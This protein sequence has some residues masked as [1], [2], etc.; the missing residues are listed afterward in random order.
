MAPILLLKVGG[1]DAPIINVIGDYE[2]WFQ[3]VIPNE[4][5]GVVDLRDE[6]P[7]WPKDFAAVIIMGSPH[8]VYA[9]LPWLPS[10]LD[11]VSDLLKKDIPVLGVCFGHQMICSV[12]GGQV[13]KSDKGYEVGTV[14]LRATPEGLADPLF[15]PLF[16]NEEMLVNE[17]H[18]DS[19]AVLPEETII[20]AENDHDSF[21]A[22]R[23]SEKVWSVQFHPEIGLT[24]AKAVMEDYRPSLEAKGLKV[25]RLIETA[26]E[27]PEA[28]SL[29][30][31]FVAYVRGNRHG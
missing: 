25:D 5:L 13:T 14:K 20:L 30:Q 21:Q 17:S 29:I 6:K 10:A 26:R 3:R 18:G 22:L 19:V 2:M 11:A 8:S 24:E 28:R 16:K 31:H 12:R 1:K 23:H 15:G 4:V 27:T 9:D 7:L